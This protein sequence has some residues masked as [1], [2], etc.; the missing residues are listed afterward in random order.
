MVIN[1]TDIWNTV[2]VDNLLDN[3]QNEAANFYSQFFTTNSQYH[4]TY[5]SKM[6]TGL[7]IFKLFSLSQLKAFSDVSHYLLSL[8]NYQR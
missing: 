6:S 7:N 8:N 2:S 5:K 4:A 1:L 3:I